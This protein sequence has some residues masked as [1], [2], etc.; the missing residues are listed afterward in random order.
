MT[1]VH[2]DGW[3]TP[4]SVESVVTHREGG[5]RGVPIG[6]PVVRPTTLGASVP[7]TTRD[8]RAVEETLVPSAVQEPVRDSL[9]DEVTG[10]VVSLGIADGAPRATDRVHSARRWAA[11]HRRRLL[12]AEAG[13][14]AIVAAVVL[15]I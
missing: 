1:R 7:A 9:V 14:A 11:R 13:L 6:T 15:L 5:L 4:V 10:S 8:V 2:T 12:A 3:T